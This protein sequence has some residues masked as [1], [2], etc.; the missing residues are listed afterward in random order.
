MKYFGFKSKTPLTKVRKYDKSQ[1]KITRAGLSSNPVER[2]NFTSGTVFSNDQLVQHGGAF[3]VG[4]DTATHEFTFETKV[5]GSVVECPMKL[6]RNADAS[7]LIPTGTWFEYTTGDQANI[8]L[9]KTQDGNPKSYPSSVNGNIS[10]FMVELDLTP[11]CNALFGGS[12]AALIAALKAINVDVWAGGSGAGGNGVDVKWW[13]G[14][15]IQRGNNPSGSISKIS[16]TL[17]TTGYVTS[18]NK[19]YVLIAS[20]F[21]SDGTIASSVS[22]DYINIK[23]DLAR[24]PDTVSPISVN[25]PKYWAMCG[26]ISPCFDNSKTTETDRIFSFFIDS[27]NRFTLVRGSDGRF[28]LSKVKTETIYQI[29]SSVQSFAKNQ[30][31]KYIVGQNA[32]G[33]FMYLLKNNG[34]VEKIT[35]S[36]TNILSGLIPLHILNQNGVEQGD[37]FAESF[38]LIDLQRLGKQ[39]GLTDAEAVSILKGQMHIKENN[40]VVNG[41]FSNGTNGWDANNSTFTVSSNTLTNIGSGT[42]LTPQSLQNLAFIATH[43]YYISAN[44]RVTNSVCL[45]IA[46]FD[47]QTDIFKSQANPIQNTWYRLGVMGTAGNTNSALIIRHTYVD[48]VTAN[49]KVMEVQDV[50]VLDLTALF[51]AGLEPTQAQCDAMFAQGTTNPIGLTNP[52]LFDISKVTLHA[53]ATRSGNT[54]VLNATGN[55]QGSYIDINVLPNNQYNLKVLASGTGLVR[56]DEYYNNTFLSIAKDYSSGSTN[57]TFITKGTTNKIRVSLSNAYNGIGTYTFS[58]ISLRRKD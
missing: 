46:I 29:L 8:D 17:T 3:F 49:G 18:S 39:N 51:G 58:N 9:V 26:S 12:N 34:T 11:L 44:V 5:A 24:T 7:L 28:S 56:I 19:F 22:L 27:S 30:T 43:K 23:I 32:S 14:A 45:S 31:Y 35:N 6:Y 54:I 57:A 37:M 33:M 36:D 2:F 42:F 15:W 20:Q 13:W 25:L 38:N 41:D 10:Q 21:A 47:T 1:I 53:N 40:L 55:Y 50:S 48:A 52:E 4:G 16:N